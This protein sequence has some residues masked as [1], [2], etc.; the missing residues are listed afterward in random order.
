MRKYD[1]ILFGATGF[2]GRQAAVYL[3]RHAPAGLRW[4]VAGRDRAK[5]ESLGLT[6]DVLVADSADQPAIDTLAAQT[7]VV[8][9]TAGPFARY[10]TPVVD[11]CVRHG[12]DYTDITGETFWV[13]SLVAKYHGA[14]AAGRVR[15]VPCCGFDS[16][17]S[18]L[19]A[20]LLATRHSAS[21]VRA[22]FQISGGGLNGGTI[23][24]VANMVASGHARGIARGGVLGPPH[25]DAWIGTWAGRS[26]WLRPTR[27]SSAAQSRYSNPG[28][29]RIQMDSVITST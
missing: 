12:T 21:R 16:V 24:S 22:Y 14:A 9:S 1:L 19:A 8:A 26:S 17:P 4:A 28:A 18:D 2:T 27:G 7:R 10:G 23:A 11:A 6:A 20:F 29:H 3:A 5:L 25:F 15:I 13:E